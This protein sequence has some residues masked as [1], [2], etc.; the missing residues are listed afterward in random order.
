MGVKSE[1]KEAS[2]STKKS[3]KISVKMRLKRGIIMDT[4]AHHNVMPKRM[5]GKRNI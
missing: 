5:A 2:G 3:K 4:G 1:S